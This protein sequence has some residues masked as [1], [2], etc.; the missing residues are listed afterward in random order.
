MK[1][2]ENPEIVLLNVTRDV[3]T[4]SDTLVSEDPS[5]YAYDGY[6]EDIFSALS[7]GN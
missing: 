1:K 2:Y 6:H 5:T 4:A 7:S 3:I